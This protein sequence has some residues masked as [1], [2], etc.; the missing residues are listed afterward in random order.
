[1]KLWRR[2]APKQIWGRRATIA[3]SII[4]I[5]LAADMIWV[6]LWRIIPIGYDTTRLTGPLRPNGTVNYT[7]ELNRIN[8][9]GVTPKNNAAPLLIDAMGPKALIGSAR[10]H[11]AIYK[12]LQMA[13]PP[14]H[15]Q[16][17]TSY[18]RWIHNHTHYYQWL[19]KH[20]VTAEQWK[21]QSSGAVSLL[22]HR[23]WTAGHRPL[24][25]AWIRANAAPLALLQKAR[26][27]PRYFI[28]HIHI[29]PIYFNSPSVRSPLSFALAEAATTRA[30]MR[31]GAGNIR[32]AL[33]DLAAV[34][35]LI[36]LLD[37]GGQ[38][39]WWTHW[40]EQICQQ[41]EAALANSKEISRGQLESLL[42][43]F[44]SRPRLRRP[45]DTYG[46]NVRY[47][48]YSRLAFL[49]AAARTGLRTCFYET[50]HWGSPFWNG[51]RHVPFWRNMLLDAL[52]PIDFPALMRRVNT[53]DDQLKAACHKP[54][55]RQR[56]AALS[57]IAPM[58]SWKQRI[59]SYN[60]GNIVSKIFHPP[61][62]LI[63]L[64]APF[65]PYYAENLNDMHEMYIM[66][67]NLTI[68]A[69]ALAIYKRDHGRYPRRL[70]ALAPQYVKA[71]PLDGFVDKPLTYHPR[72][73]GQSFLL[74]S[75]ARKRWP[76][77]GGFIIHGGRPF[78]AGPHR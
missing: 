5:L 2:L 10:D 58:I 42:A 69:I 44:G 34:R 68:L 40:I 9:A 4:L 67:R 60:N 16:F 51:P 12:M 57:A 25:A 15:A 37:Q 71:I 66:R 46:L 50:N 52:V 59:E 29:I 7:A 18:Y 70:A 22:S 21:L 54:T 65:A 63:Y 32:G 75:A 19:R 38:I 36:H 48:R 76:G 72:D 78:P 41:D 11:R 61:G 33:A 3:L 64:F 30:M 28:P 8:S 74:E 73:H 77:A 62:I 14:A 31:L 53:I 39:L 49:M 6:R 20:V 27:F 13:P 56:A 17:V 26:A 24:V 43:E 55:Y 23:P 1:M 47:L 35:H 45:M